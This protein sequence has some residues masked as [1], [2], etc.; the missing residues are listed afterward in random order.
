MK[1]FI[2][3]IAIAAVILFS[4]GALIYARPDEQP[5]KENQINEENQINKESQINDEDQIDEEDQEY[6]DTENED[7]IKNDKEEDNEEI[8]VKN[9]KETSENSEKNTINISINGYNISTQPPLGIKNQ[10]T[11]KIGRTIPVKFML[12]DAN[13]DIVENLSIKLY[14][15][16]IE[17]GVPGSEIQ[18]TSS[19][20]SND[21]NYFRF[22]KNSERYIFNLSTKGFS[23]GTWRLKI[24][25]G[26]GTIFYTD[27]TLG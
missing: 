19:G 6:S 5:N 18:A 21:G 22:S 16:K 8:S 20:K 14:L 2:T 27:I 10:K 13:G 3:G 15:A 4:T 12:T 17:N 24:D 23:P 9:D 7:S 25:L 26:N 11:F 1:K